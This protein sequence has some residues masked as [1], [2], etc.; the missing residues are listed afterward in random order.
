MDP[1]TLILTALSS[2]RI[3]LSNPLLG[4]GSSVKFDEASNLL[5]VLVD[6]IAQGDD[7]LDDLRAFAVTVKAMADEGRG[8]TRQEYEFLR[9]RSDAAYDN[10]QVVKGRLLGEQ[11]EED[12]DDNDSEET[13]PTLTPE[14]TT[15]TETGG[16]EP[17]AAQPGEGDRKSVV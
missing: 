11:Q 6:L 16:E 8:P 17:P 13:Q 15:A 9:Q 2:L 4:G 10:L 3:V 5:G 7:G 1:V 12:S 14:A